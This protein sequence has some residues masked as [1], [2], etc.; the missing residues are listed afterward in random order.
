MNKD[1]LI[2]F[3]HV[4]AELEKDGIL[5]VRNPLPYSVNVRLYTEKAKDMQQALGVLPFLR[6]R[7]I[8]LKPGETISLKTEEEKC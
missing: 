1:L 2:V 6:Y 5:K 4:E 8:S 3:D 7:N